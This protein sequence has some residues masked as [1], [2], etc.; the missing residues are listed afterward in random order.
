VILEKLKH[1]EDRDG[2][3]N[4]KKMTKKMFRALTLSSGCLLQ[5]QA[6]RISE[7][8]GMMLKRLRSKNFMYLME[9]FK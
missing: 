3:E 4:V 2:Y 9:L 6:T 5:A 8:L 1:V 7:M